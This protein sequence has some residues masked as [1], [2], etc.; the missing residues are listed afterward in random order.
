MNA[1]FG[2]IAIF[3][4]SL[5]LAGG[6][7]PRHVFRADAGY[8]LN[9]KAVDI[10][11]EITN[12][13]QLIADIKTAGQEEKRPE[14]YYSLALLFS[15][16]NNP[17]PD[18]GLALSSLQHYVELAG[19]AGKKAEVR[20]LNGLLQRLDE[21]AGMRE[22]CQRIDE[23][24]THLEQIRGGL[25]KKLEVL[26][27]EKTHLEQICSGLQEKLEDLR[28]ENL[29]KQKAIEQLRMLDMRLEQKKRIVQ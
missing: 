17:Q 24:K 2:V 6:C 13:E 7:V 8:Y 21:L 15:H 11:A 27:K 26:K 10:P 14:L 25:Q 18:Y 12:L 23:E 20:Y 28:K 5:F 1:R 3:V 4:V 9:L 29:E 19:E 22:Q 16:Y